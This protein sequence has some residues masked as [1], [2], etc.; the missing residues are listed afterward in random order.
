MTDESLLMCEVVNLIV[1]SGSL[2]INI[3]CPQVAQPHRREK[4]SVP[5]MVVAEAPL[6]RRCLGTSPVHSVP[7]FSYNRPVQSKR[8][9][10]HV[11]TRIL[12]QVMNINCLSI[13][14][15]HTR[16]E[17]VACQ[18]HCPSLPP[19]PNSLFPLGVCTA[20]C[21]IYPGLI[22]SWCSASLLLALTLTATNI[23]RLPFRIRN[24]KKY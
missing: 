18:T 2:Q 1:T 20:V 23:Y 5:R 3:V 24:K 11:L 10:N 8:A 16:T 6:T 13:R 12:I 17:T 19:F 9:H 4:L 21:S 22:N 15:R 7:S 14:A